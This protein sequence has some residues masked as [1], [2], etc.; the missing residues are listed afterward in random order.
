M[1][2]FVLDYGIFALAIC[3]FLDDLSFPFPT[4]TVLFSTAVFART[5][6]NISLFPIILIA[7]FIPPIANGIMFYFGKHGA[8]KF[9]DKHGHRFLLPEQR[10][11]KAENI[12]KKY[13]DK[14]IFFVAML[15][16]VRPV[17]SMIAGSLNMKTW[18]FIIFHFA[19]IIIWNI[20]IF[21]SGYF[22]GIK[23]WNIIKEFFIS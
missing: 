17:C 21:G 9:L 5:N 22:F 7:L 12:L 13:G 2:N 8:R 16:S 10:I 4:A 23:I 18:K 11:K 6:P 3:L 15:P 19:G 20:I 14:T 1:E